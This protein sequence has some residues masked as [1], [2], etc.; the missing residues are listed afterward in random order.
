M[1]SVSIDIDHA[2]QKEWF[3]KTDD[4]RMIV[5]GFGCID[6]REFRKLPYFKTSVSR[7]INQSITLNI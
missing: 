4:V 7:Q 1:F 2:R 6:Y 3:M 5:I